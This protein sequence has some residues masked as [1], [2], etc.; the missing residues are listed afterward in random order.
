M[1]RTS[2]PL[3][4]YLTTSCLRTTLGTSLP[5][6]VLTE[7]PGL[8][9]VAFSSLTLTFSEDTHFCL[10]CFLGYRPTDDDPFLPTSSADASVSGDDHTR[11]LA[12]LCYITWTDDQHTQQAK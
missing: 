1:S 3:P 9:W 8:T 7:E 11:L 5:V 2:S 4:L 10:H 6:Q 12:S